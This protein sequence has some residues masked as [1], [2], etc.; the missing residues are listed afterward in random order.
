MK[1]PLFITT[2]EFAGDIPSGIRLRKLAP[3]ERIGQN[4]WMTSTSNLP[5][6]G[7]IAT[8]GWFTGRSP[9]ETYNLAFYREVKKPSANTLNPPQ[10]A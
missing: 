9:S 10:D 7:L 3:R 8:N 2:K 4:D 1:H 5:G 6:T